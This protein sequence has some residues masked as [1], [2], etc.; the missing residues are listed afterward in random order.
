MIPTPWSPAWSAIILIA[1]ICLGTVAV[2]SE[3][4]LR[5][6]VM[7]LDTN[8]LEVLLR[9]LDVTLLV[10]AI[11]IAGATFFIG[12]RGSGWI[13]AAAKDEVDRLKLDIEKHMNEQ[14]DKRKAETRAMLDTMIGYVFGETA[15]HLFREG[16]IVRSENRSK[17][18]QLLEEAIVYARQGLTHAS[19][20][21]KPIALNN[22]V[23]FLA[24]IG[25]VRDAREVVS[26]AEQLMAL[27][28]RDHD[29]DFLTTYAKAVVAYQHSFPER[30]VR[31]ILGMLGA[32]LKDET[33]NE[34][35]KN[36][37]RDRQTELNRILPGN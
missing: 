21:L 32:M 25:D 2:A 35:Q 29:A 34:R 12:V 28:Q 18:L 30:V 10:L 8:S 5:G 3:S 16:D 14:E 27:Y 33:I 15:R 31:E 17:F 6:Q 13:K 37:A 22:L 23:F 26:L 36:S 20:N 7:A 1:W 11:V 4:G 19:E 24:E 9:F